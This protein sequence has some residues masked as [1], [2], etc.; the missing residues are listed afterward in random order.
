MKKN[1]HGVAGALAIGAKHE[2]RKVSKTSQS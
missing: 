2:S 1:W